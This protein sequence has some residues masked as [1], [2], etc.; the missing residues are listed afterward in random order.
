MATHTLTTLATAAAL[1]AAVGSTARSQPPAPQPPETP[2]THTQPADAAP[3]PVL[4][5]VRIDRQQQVVELDATVVQPTEEW[6]EL[7]ACSPKTYQYESL[8]TVHARPNHVHL[9]LLLIGLEP[10]RPMSWHEEDGRYVIDPPQGPGVAVTLVYEKQGQTVEV[11]A[12]EW[13]VHIETGDM[14]PNNHWLFAGST[15]RQIDDQEVYAADVSGAV[16]SLVNFG[17]DVLARPTDI[18]NK[19]GGAMWTANEAVIPPAD[20]PVIIRLR[21][22]EDQH[23][24]E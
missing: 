23:P 17:S 4:P 3:D 21:P 18:S 5:H 7:L 22:V 8:L 6:I 14:M 9:A 1:L 15:F 13:I 11:R 24:Q 20:T 19:G 16:L 2:P 12:N 10:G